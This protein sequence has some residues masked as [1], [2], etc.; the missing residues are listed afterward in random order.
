L[1]VIEAIPKEDS[2]VVWGK[3]IVKIRQD[4]VLQA[5][6]F[7]DQEMKLVKRL[8]TLSVRDYS[9]KIFPETMR[10]QNMEEEDEWTEITHHS[11]V[12]GEDYPESLFSISHLKNPRM[13]K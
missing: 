6:L 13:M 12:F 11:I 3:E 1:K 9:G 2:P 5:H 4:K 10:M 8:R 7:Y